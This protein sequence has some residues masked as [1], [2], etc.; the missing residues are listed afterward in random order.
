M[1]RLLSYF[2]LMLLLLPVN[3]AAGTPDHLIR[4]ASHQHALI[5]GAVV[6]KDTDKQMVMFETHSVLLGKPV[7]QKISISFKGRTMPAYTTGNYM[8]FSVS[9]KSNGAYAYKWG[10]FKVSSLDALSLKILNGR[11]LGW[12]PTPKIIKS[13][14]WWV[15]HGRGYVEEYEIGD[16]LFIRCKNGKFKQIYPTELAATEEVPSELRSIFKGEL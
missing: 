12:K 5:L 7:E 9:K 13:F 16:K 2:L 10:V 15:N 8:I 4:Q 3:A 6:E 14:E 11:I 1:Q